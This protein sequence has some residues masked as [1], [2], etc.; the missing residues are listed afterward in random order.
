MVSGTSMGYTWGDTKMPVVPKRVNLDYGL[1]RP[2]GSSPN[3]K[4]QKGLGETL[5]LKPKP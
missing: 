5:W 2:C 4:P 3:P 1:V